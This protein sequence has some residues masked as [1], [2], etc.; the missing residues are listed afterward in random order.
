MQ[1]F[2]LVTL[3]ES[4]DDKDFY[5]VQKFLVKGEMVAEGYIKGRFRKRGQKHSVS[6]SELFKI[7]GKVY[8]EPKL[9]SLAK[10]QDSVES[11]LC[12]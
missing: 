10:A 12:Q 5:I 4:W 3:V 6:T 2:E 1:K 11:H 9:S 8:E 7:L